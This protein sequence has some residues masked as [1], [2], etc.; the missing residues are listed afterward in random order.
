M[1]VS[2]RKK[3][4]T[5]ERSKLSRFHPVFSQRKPKIWLLLLLC[6][7]KIYHGNNI[8]GGRW[9]VLPY[10]NNQ[11]T[12]KV[13]PT[14]LIQSK[15]MLGS[16]FFSYLHIYLFILL[17]NNILWFPWGVIDLFGLIWTKT[18]FSLALKLSQKTWKGIYWVLWLR[19][20]SFFIYFK[21][22]SNESLS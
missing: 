17:W 7:R 13:S 16:G 14:A 19:R 22:D 21:P 20:K 12:S 5:K 9:S 2:Y 11:I 6:Q 8:K 3:N 10:S 4:S 1:S 18:G 15:D